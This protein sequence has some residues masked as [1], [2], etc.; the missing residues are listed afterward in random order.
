[1][2]SGLRTKATQYGVKLV[3]HRAYWESCIA[4]ITGAIGLAFPI[5][6][7]GGISDEIWENDLPYA[8]N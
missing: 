4:I 6:V 7:F 3:E 1:M 2:P 8:P 5:N